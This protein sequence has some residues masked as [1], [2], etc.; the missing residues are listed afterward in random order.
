MG[1]AIIKRGDKPKK[2]LRHLSKRMP[3]FKSRQGTNPKRSSGL[4]I[5]RRPSEERMNP[6]RSLDT[7]VER[8]LSSK[9]SPSLGSSTLSM[10]VLS[11]L[12]AARPSLGLSPSPTF[13]EGL[14]SPL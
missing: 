7:L 12:R 2:E 1:R 11:L 10:R 13:K 14:G 3:F 8:P 5:G 4:L 6:K 9:I